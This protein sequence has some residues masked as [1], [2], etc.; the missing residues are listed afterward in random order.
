MSISS[1]ISGKKNLGSDVFVSLNPA[2][3]FDIVGQFA[4]A[5]LDECVE[6]CT[7]A[8]KGFEKWKNTPAPVRAEVIANFGTL[9]TKNKEALSQILTREMGKPIKEA[10]GDVQEAIDTCH[11]FVSEGRR[12]YGHT[13]PSEMPNKE[14]FTYRR[15]LGVF[16]CITAGNFPFAVPSWYFIPALVCGNSCVWKP[17]EDTPTLSLVFAELL[18]AAGVPHDVFHVL[19]GTGP[20]TGEKLLSLVD[21]GLIDKVGF[22]GSTE[23]GR[24]IGEICGRNLQNPC[25]ELGGK[26]PMVVMPDADLDLVAHGA[27]WSGFG[28]A[29][30]RCTSLGNL[31]VHKSVKDSLLKKIMDKIAIMSIGEPTNENNFY[32]PMIGERFL[33]KHLENLNTLV[34]PHHKLLFSQNGAITT[35]NKPTHFN[36]KADSG[37]YAFPTIVDNVTEND[38]IFSTET[39]G[40]L[41]NVLSFS[42]LDEAIYLSNKTGFG[43]SSSIYTNN[44]EASYQFRTQISAGMT[45]INNSTTGAEAHLPFGGNGK[46]GNGSRQS[47]I[48]VIDQFTKWQSVNW[49]MSGKLQL[50]QMDTHYIQSSDYLVP[51]P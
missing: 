17:S 33:N 5:T 46:S 47:G 40:P 36:G 15:P 35:A 26:N 20:N 28:T 39:F 16:A 48:W 29:G 18:Y 51:H 22:T 43:L 14:L 30:Q 50:A 45:S 32:G 23:V 6:A 42:T 8:R 9:I 24:K 19:F 12:L 2:N 7:Q 49:D 37:F 38:A 27:V 1:I 10:R 41:F 34:K 25:L 3:K 21:K 44:I 13:V 4:N 31:I 11:F